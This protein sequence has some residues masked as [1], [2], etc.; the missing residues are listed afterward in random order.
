MNASNN[1]RNTVQTHNIQMQDTNL[2]IKCCYLFKFYFNNTAI[3]YVLQLMIILTKDIENKA[4][5]KACPGTG[6]F[7]GYSNCQLVKKH[8]TLTMQ[9]NNKSPAISS[10]S[11]SILE[12]GSRTAL[13]PQVSAS[14]LQFFIYRVQT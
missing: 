8:E 10:I 4:T 13:R 11:P 9:E 12:S 7:A 14:F 3:L 6:D 1:N 2:H 5:I